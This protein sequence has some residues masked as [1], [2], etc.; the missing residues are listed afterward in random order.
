MERRRVL[1]A[2][3]WPRKKIRWGFR[4]LVRFLVAELRC[5]DMR[6]AVD[7]LRAVPRRKVAF[8]GDSDRLWRL[9]GLGKRCLAALWA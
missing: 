3:V 4:E 5:Q 6:I 1:I 8:L 2:P 9:G 7:P